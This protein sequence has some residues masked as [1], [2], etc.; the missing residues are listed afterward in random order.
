[1]AWE[2]EEHVRGWFTT[3]I[4]TVPRHKMMS[5]A[6]SCLSEL[7][8]GGGRAVVEACFTRGP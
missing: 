2:G 8:N 3:C 6:M 7:Q 5:C 4:E 1:M